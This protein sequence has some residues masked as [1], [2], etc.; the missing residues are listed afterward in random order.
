VSS[1]ASDGDIIRNTAALTSAAQGTINS[2]AVNTQVLS[3]PSILTVKTGLP[4]PVRMGDI[5]TY[6]IQITNEASTNLT[7]LV[8]TDPLP[9]HTAFVS[10]DL[11]GILK[12]NDIV[13]SLGTLAGG[14][15]G[16]C[17]AGTAGTSL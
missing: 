17:Y 3:S 11:G 5:I 9:D 16:N 8:I 13:W 14:A 12:G 7:G 6:T 10:A 1:T 2:N 4:D 15:I